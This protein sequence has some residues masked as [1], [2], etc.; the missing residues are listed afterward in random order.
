[1]VD[2]LWFI[3]G[4][5]D[6]PY[7]G[8]DINKRLPSHDYLASVARVVDSL[9]YYGALL[10]TGFGCED[11]W[12][13]AASLFPLT[14]RMKFLIAFRPGSLSPTLAARMAAT[15]DRMSGGRLLLN[16]ITGGDP[17]ELKGDGTFE[18]HDERYAISDEFLTVWR[19]IMQG[20]T[21]SFEGKYEHVEGARINFPPVQKPYP[22]LY[23][24]GSSDSGIAVAAK[25]IDVYLSLIE[26]PEMIKPKIEKAREAAAK[27]G[28]EIEIGI[29]THIITRDTM[30]EAWSAANA[31]L[32]HVTP[33]AIEAHRQK[34]A[35]FDSVGQ[36][37]MME[38]S[39]STTNG[40]DALEVYPN[41]WAG[42]SVV[43]KGLGTAIV[44]TPDI[45]A[46]RLQQY[47]ELG[48]SKFILSSYPHLE[49]CYRVA[50]TVL[51]LCS[52][53]DP[54]KNLVSY[55]PGATSEWQ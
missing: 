43:N 36:S 19:A 6:G 2:A 27:E 11:S 45:V 39:K 31:V 23:F 52:W 1:M 13:I 3:P 53:W 35:R 38:L 17:V 32:K 47:V 8:T 54:N 15:M 49:E 18:S 51:P 12:V 34:M 33:E 14:T 5:G 29:R 26:P 30:E 44:G 50:E 7:L 42:F 40:R 28:R 41:L 22:P 46:E 48:A 37:R 25:H 16:I 20:E 24:G 9:G 21:F 4:H 55:Q 10:P